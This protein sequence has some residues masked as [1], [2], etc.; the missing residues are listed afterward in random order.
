MDI[1]MRMEWIMRGRSMQADRTIYSFNGYFL[2]IE[3]QPINA[4][5]L[6]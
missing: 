5:Y 6:I 4:L 2:P 3:H 1:V